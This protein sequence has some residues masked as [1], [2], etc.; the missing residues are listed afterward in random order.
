MSNPK[1]SVI[2]PVYN[3]GT[4]LYRCAQS[5]LSQTEQ[6]LELILV[7]D[8][9]S[10]GSENICD[11]LAQKDPRVRVIHKE[12]AGVSEAR[13]DGIAAAKGTFVG[14]LD[15]DDWAEPHMFACMLQQQA[16]TDSE[17]VYC[18]FRR[19]YADRTEDVSF[20]QERVY[21][22]EEIRELAQEMFEN[23][24]FS[25]VWRGLYMRSILD[26][27][28][29]DKNIHYAEDLIFNLDVLRKAKA[30]AV[31]PDVLYLYDQ[32]NEGSATQRGMRDPD[33]RFNGSLQRKLEANAYWQFPV[34]P[35]AFY[36]EYV[37]SMFL[38]LVKKL[39]AG[40]NR[41]MVRKTV[42]EG[43]FST[44]CMYDGNIPAY[45]RVVGRLIRKGHFRT[46]VLV[47]SAQE[48]LMKLMGR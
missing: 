20:P 5:V 38:Y 10:D 36:K 35:N 8:G 47:R 14:F 31:V 17:V 19:I 23:R 43:F 26:G 40:G 18:G 48:L 9:S 44:C 34:D 41:E 29:F 6:E 4:Y 27:V 7:D 39:Q 24:T 46:A 32:T 3:A 15:A 21:A 13:N 28:K 1:V 12:N 33:F 42:T 22:G 30:V 45:R 11:E 25:A 37:D 2:V 16:R